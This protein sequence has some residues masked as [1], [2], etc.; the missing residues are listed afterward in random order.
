MHLQR[1][2]PLLAAIGIALTP[3]PSLPQS[4]SEVSSTIVARCP[5]RVTPLKQVQPA[6]PANAK[7]NGIQGLV[8]VKAIIDREGVPGHFEVLKGPRALIPAALEALKQW[9]Y[10]PFVMDGKAVEVEA[11]FDI[12][13]VIPEKA[14]AQ[15]L[16]GTWRPP[17]WKK[18]YRGVVLHIVPSEEGIEGTVHFW[19]PGSDHEST[20]LNPKLEGNTFL[21]DVDD[22]YAGKLTFSM[23]VN[24]TGKVAALSGH[25]REMLFDFALYKAIP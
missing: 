4:K 24:E 16:I 7:A 20:M 14:S 17:H 9:R 22:D 15:R 6:Y 2:L 23:T 10:K 1:S 13:F 3:N 25:G 8:R 11:S 21:F 12:N 18:G 19:D 5:A